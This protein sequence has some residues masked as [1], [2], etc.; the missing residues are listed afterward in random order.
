M[1]DEPICLLVRDHV[2]FVLHAH[3]LGVACLL[4][5]LVNLYKYW[6]F[7]KF[8]IPAEMYRITGGKPIYLVRMLNWTIFGTVWFLFPA[9][10]LTEARALLRLSIT[11]IILS[12]ILYN[13]YWIASMFKRVLR[14]SL[15]WLHS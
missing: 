5:A 13:W 7:R 12:E 2:F 8:P 14:W 6:R 4:L 3:I 10:P 1:C 9:I 15:N 11:F